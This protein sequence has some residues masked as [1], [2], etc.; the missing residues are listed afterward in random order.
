MTF[1]VLTADPFVGRDDGPVKQLNGSRIAT[2]EEVSKIFSAG[3]FKSWMKRID[4][5]HK[6]IEFLSAGY[7]VEEI[8]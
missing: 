7:N 1:L 4:S 3:I 6:L 8:M 5:I 2:F